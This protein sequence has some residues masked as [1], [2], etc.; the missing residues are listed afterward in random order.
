MGWFW[1]GRFWMGRFWMGRFAWGWNA[2]YVDLVVAE[3]D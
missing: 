1:M 2:A 3:G